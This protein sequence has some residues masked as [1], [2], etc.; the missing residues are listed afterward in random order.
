[1]ELLVQA[2]LSPV[3]ALQT[4]TR[5]PTEYLDK[6]DSAGT[7]AEGKRAD[8]VLLGADP[9]A[10]IS[11]TRRIDGVVAAGVLLPRDRLDAMLTEVEAVTAA[12]SR[13]G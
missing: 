1:M 7:I 6:L 2:G 8:L 12:R 13:A 4:A 5:N 10:D 3:Q 11:N 9:L